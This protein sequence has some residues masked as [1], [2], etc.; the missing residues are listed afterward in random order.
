MVLKSKFLTVMLMVLVFVGPAAANTIVPCQHDTEPQLT[1]TSM[2]PAVLLTLDRADTASDMIDC[3]YQDGDC[4]MGDCGSVMLFSASVQAWDLI[5]LQ[6][7]T[8]ANLLV[9]YRSPPSLYRP[10]I[11]G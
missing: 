3:C 5:T 4:P 9:L 11:T 2:A 10:P 6:K 7:N 1:M 8:S